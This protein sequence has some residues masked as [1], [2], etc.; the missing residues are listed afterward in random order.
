M[1]GTMFQRIKEYKFGAQTF[2]NEHQ[3]GFAP[4]KCRYTF[5]I[6]KNLYPWQQEGNSTLILVAVKCRC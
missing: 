3:I 5:T 4:N 2:N 6:T 1:C